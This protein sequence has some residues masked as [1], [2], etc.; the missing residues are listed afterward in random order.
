MVMVQRYDLQRLAGQYLYIYHRCYTLGAN[1]EVVDGLPVNHN[2]LYICWQN[3]IVQVY[4]H[5]REAIS[6]FV[7]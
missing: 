7:F 6:N 3:T 1:I 5:Y 2:Y 4:V